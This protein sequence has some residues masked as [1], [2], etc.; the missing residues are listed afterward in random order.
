ML[1][2]ITLSAVP[3]WIR[4]PSPPMRV[5]KMLSLDRESNK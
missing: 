1:Q 3:T 2:I 4:D 5:R